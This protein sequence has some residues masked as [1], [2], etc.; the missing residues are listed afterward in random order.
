MQT[1]SQV[2]CFS[3][4]HS[5][6]PS[7]TFLFF[8]SSDFQV[9]VCV[10]AV[11]GCG[12][13]CERAKLLS[14]PERVDESSEAVQL[15][16]DLYYT[17]FLISVMGLALMIFYLH[18]ITCFDVRHDMAAIRHKKSLTTAGLLLIISFHFY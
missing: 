3:H 2:S 12:D 5:H 6:T 17:S 14:N 15:M 9:S 13:S 10:I 11:V 16:Q 1:H 4:S 8:K 18:Y 7:V